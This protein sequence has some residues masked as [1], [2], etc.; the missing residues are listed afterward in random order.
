MKELAKT[1]DA[2]VG[3]VN[4]STG[5]A[6]TSILTAA[7]DIAL[8]LDEAGVIRDVTLGQS[9]QP[10]EESRGW[11]GHGWA[12]TVTPESRP[13]IQDMLREA[14]ADGVSRRRQVNHLSATGNDIPIAYTT[15]R[16]KGEK[17]LVAI[18]RDLSSV[19]ALQQRLVEAQ[20]SLERDY[21]R[22]RHIE[23]RYRLLFQ[24]SSEAVLVVDAATQKVVEANP[25]AA[26]L[27]DSSAKKL[28]GRP[29][30]FEMDRSAEGAVQDLLATVRAHGRGDDLTVRLGQSGQPCVLSISLVR[31]DTQ[32]LF[33]VRVLPQGHQEIGAGGEQMLRAS[34]LV[35]AIPDAF[36]AADDEGRVLSANR[37]FLDLVEMPTEDQVRGQPLSRWIGR[38][39]ADL[40]LMLATMREHG[41]V[42]LFGTALRGELGSSSEVEVSG[43]VLPDV[44][45]GVQGLLIRD[46]GRRIA[47]GP[48]GARDLTRAVEQLTAL[49][50]RVSLK[51]LVRDT[52][53]LVERHF[54]EAALEMTDDNRTSASEVLGVSRQS[55][56]VKLRRYN[57]APTPEQGSTKAT[58]TKARKK[59]R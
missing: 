27:F 29:F 15:V 32:S 51:N 54:I 14:A 44:N 28:V 31:Q 30:P 8:V 3:A 11:L 46:V 34:R 48:R 50:G 59:K 12:D 55:L 4:E 45:N 56:Y 39:G 23:T 53:D 22:M 49:V 9:D 21:W 20:Q 1:F 5:H 18:G 19:S 41:V 17:Q 43:V 35:Q 26:V 36:V 2:K 37:A 40:G 58:R 6:V 7:S 38:P 25:A 42:R 52:A 57:M 33:L 10:I 24:V 13:K 16:L 47:L